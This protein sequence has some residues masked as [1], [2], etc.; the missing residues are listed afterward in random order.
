MIPFLQREI[1]ERY[2]VHDNNNNL[3][4]KSSVQHIGSWLPLGYRH[5]YHVQSQY[6]R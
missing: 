1:L 6:R 5:V 2:G 3:P 4:L